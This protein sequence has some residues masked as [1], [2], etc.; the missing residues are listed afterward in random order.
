MSGFFDRETGQSN[1][2]SDEKVIKAIL[3]QAS[4][5]DMFKALTVEAKQSTEARALSLPFFLNRYPSFPIWLGIRSVPWQRDVFGSLYK[6]FT[7]IPCYVAWESVEETKHEDDGRPVGCVFTWPG[8]GVCCIHQYT[9]SILNDKE[10]FWISRTIKKGRFIIEPLSQ[11]L[12][13]IDWKPV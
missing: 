11:L 12:A 8:F 4:A 2:V 9:P 10:G 6:R 3:K 13:T 7:A 1:F 5:S